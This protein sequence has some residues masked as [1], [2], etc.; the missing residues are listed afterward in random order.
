MLTM[1]E[2]SGLALA[3]RLEDEKSPM[4]AEEPSLRIALFCHSIVSDWNH[5]NAH[6]LRGLVRSLKKLGHQVFTL[7]E[8]ENWSLSNLVRDHGMQPVVDFR[9]HFPFIENRSYVLNGRTHLY[10]WLS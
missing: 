3:S 5:G 7:E 10:E 8:E 2:V 1:G 6:F 9:R 4:T